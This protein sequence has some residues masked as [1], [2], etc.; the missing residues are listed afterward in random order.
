[1]TAPGGSASPAPA[2]AV[3]DSSHPPSLAGGAVAGLG[4]RRSWAGQA[5]VLAGFVAAGIVV[6]W[7]RARYLAGTLP[8]GGDQ[9]QYVWNMWW[10]AHQLT[11]LG[12]P[13]S[14]SYLAAPVGIPLGFDTLMPLPG[15]LMAPVTLLFG[16]PVSYNLLAIVMPGLAGYAMYRVGRLWLPG[17]IGPLAAGAFY[18]LSGMLAFQAWSHLQTATGS[19]F[20]PLAMEAAVRLRRQVS[21]GRGVIL[22]VVIGAAV[23]VDQESALLAAILAVLVLLPWL[24][25]RGGRA[26]WLAA[27]AGAMTAL[28]IASGQLAAMAQEAVTGGR[29]APHASNY[30]RYT[31]QL[32][33]LFA[34][35]PRLAEDGVVRLG[36][37]LQA[38][39]PG[40]AL[41]TFGVVLSVLAVLGLW[42]SWRRRSA[43]LLG[44]LWL[45]GAA[46]SLGP[47]L[48]I[49]GHVL[50]PLAQ[51]WHGLRVSAIM[52]YTWFIRAP[53]LSSF[54]EADRLA[55][56]GLA[57]AALLAGAAVAWLRQRAPLAIIAVVLLGA[58]EAGWPGGPHPGT[59][60]AALPAVDHPIAADHSGSVVVDV[61]F[62]IVGVPGQFGAFP[63]SLALVLAT[64]DGHPR[65]ISYGPWTAPATIARIRRHAFYAGLVAAAAGRPVSRATFA[66]AGRDLRTLRIGW[67]L[68]WQRRWLLLPHSHSRPY[69]YGA[70]V[71]Y[72]RQTGFHPAYQIDGVAV[73]RP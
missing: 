66:A 36:P 13:W 60:P 70:V 20:L 73:Y 33:G 11:H 1:V 54:R 45:G 39:R 55:L 29:I 67:V 17:Q 41:A 22:G 19:V 16:P 64:A 24:I 4:P 30:V 57:A 56:L 5:A 61:P 63:S 50:V 37:M 47:A 65:A 68:L 31:A 71:S 46:L 38:P 53:G 27:G 23:L 28:V 35:S 49:A 2:A 7:P 3:S 6:T 62:G 25:P 44:L 58:M 10:A 21:I 14:T 42:V 8:A 32:P 12:S 15:A 48:S 69:D 34:L 43:R 40:D 72:L 52:P 59:M 51:R 26:E 9:A 18:G